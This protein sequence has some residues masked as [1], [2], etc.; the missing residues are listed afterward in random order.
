M[1]VGIG[2][3]GEPGIQV[4]KTVSAREMADLILDLILPDRQIGREDQ[5][6]VLVSGLGAIPLMEQYILY[7]KLSRRLEG[8][9]ISA[10]RPFVGNLFTSLE[11]MG[12]T[13]TVL[14]LADELRACLDHPCQSIGLTVGAQSGGAAS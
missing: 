7:G 12:V 13:V 5:V 10:P 8:E 11:M 14:K 4:Q 3:H 9:G 1:E 2:H 6:V